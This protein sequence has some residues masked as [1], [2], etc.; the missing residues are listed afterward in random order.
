MS[1]GLPK[2]L[3]PWTRVTGT[4]GEPG[5]TWA[6]GLLVPTA[7]VLDSGRADTFTAAQEALK[8]ACARLSAFAEKEAA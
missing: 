1:S 4:K 5:A 2:K 7:H 8:Q 3:R 6:V